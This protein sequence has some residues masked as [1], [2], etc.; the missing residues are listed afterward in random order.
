MDFH[1]VSFTKLDQNAIRPRRTHNDSLTGDAA[2]DL[3]PL[4]DINIPPFTV[5]TVSTGLK[6]LIPEG[7][8]I[9]F[10]ERSGLSAK[11][12]QIHG[13]VIDQNY[14]GELKVVLY[15][16]INYTIKINKETAIVQFTL[17]E[18]RNLLFEELTKEQFEEIAINTSRGEKGFGSS[19]V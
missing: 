5:M 9:K 14:L 6:F 8:W 19:D 18:M 13:G 7:Y 11:G 4:Y 17:E 10:H 16:S 2:Y 12:I 3:F 1:T 15:N